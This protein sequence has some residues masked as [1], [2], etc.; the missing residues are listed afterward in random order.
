LA[1]SAI[2]PLRQAAEKRGLADFSSMWAGQN[3]AGCLEIPAA[4]LTERI[5][6]A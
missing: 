3:A 2:L 5:A 1:A 4:Q 6:D